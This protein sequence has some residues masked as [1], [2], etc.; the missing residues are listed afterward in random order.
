MKIHADEEVL[1]TRK[2]ALLE[3]TI[4]ECNQFLS[5]RKSANKLIKNREKVETLE[6]R[7]LDFWECFEDG[8][9]CFKDI[10]QLEKA[11]EKAKANCCVLEAKYHL[12][13]QEYADFPSLLSIM[14]EAEPDHPFRS[15][16]NRIRDIACSEEAMTGPSTNETL[17]LCL[18]GMVLSMIKAESARERREDVTAH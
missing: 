12:G 14:V 18:Q 15:P 4:R 9:G 3:D 8:H 10:D 16:Y 6:E 13:K 5:M 2:L 17:C 7:I 11:L 1:L